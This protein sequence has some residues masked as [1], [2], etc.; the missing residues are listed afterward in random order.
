MA[1]HRS[2]PSGGSTPSDYTIEHVADRVRDFLWD[3]YV[4]VHGGAEPATPEEQGR[5]LG[6]LTAG[7]SCDSDDPHVF[8][9][10]LGEDGGDQ[11]TEHLVDD[12]GAMWWGQPEAIARIVGGMSLDALP[13]AMVNV[14]I[15][16]DEVVPFYNAVRAQVAPQMIPPGHA[17]PGRHRP[18]RVP[19]LRH[20]P[21][22]PILPW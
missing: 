9:V 6:F 12:T 5:V 2:G 1:S 13:P 16:P 4:P 15:S 21:V 8:T 18:G 10:S 22:R 20:H 19:G 14:G 7:Y 17:H 11:V 3:K